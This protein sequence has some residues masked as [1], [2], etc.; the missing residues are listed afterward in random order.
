M[1]ESRN[2]KAR[3]AVLYAR[4]SS[5]EQ[6]LGY[7]IAAQQDLLRRYGAERGL[8]IEEFSD[9]ETAKTTGRP[10]FNAMLEYLN[11]HRDCRVVL[12]EKTDR[13][14]RN[15]KDHVTLAE[16]DLEIHFVKENSILTKES[17]SSD[18]FMHGLKL[19]MAKNYID[20]LSEEV[21]KGVRTKAGQGLWP[22][23][24]PLGYVNTIRVD[25]K[26]IIVP[27]P[28]LGPIV[29]QIFE[30]FASGE[31][32]LKTLAKKAYAAGFRFRK[33]GSKIPLTTLHK[34]LRKRIYTGDFKYGGTTY[35]GSHE[36][37]V[38]REVWDQV[39]EIL[40]G[41]HANKHRKVAHDF[42]Y[43]GLVRCGHC[44]CSMVGEVKKGRYVY[45]HCTGYRGKCP[46][47]YIREEML[48]EQ[49]GG[50]LRDLVVPPAVL[51]WLQS[52][53]VAS[54]QS[55]QAARA[56][57]ARR[58]QMEL[59]R[60]QGRLDVLYKDRLDGRIELST[61]D[62]KAGEIREQQEQIR[63]KIRT[64]ESMGIPP[65][66]EAVD[67]ITLASKAADPFVA[68]TAA[69]QRKLLHLVLKEASW[70]GGELRMLLREPF[71]ELRLSNSGSDRNSKDFDANGSNYD[72]WRR[73]RDSNPH[74]FFNISNLQIAGCCVGL[75]CQGCHGSLAHITPSSKA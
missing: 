75:D 47:P 45:Y 73:E 42:V 1:A 39:Q 50:V 24:A 51:A 43:S 4:V 59:E 22:S 26:R 9:V 60:L 31:Y 6:E 55:E 18:K 8:E 68:Q 61:Y 58:Q 69:E 37:L 66:S 64:I 29:T 10:G 28:V 70:K 21:K 74:G 25:G 32:S 20:N 33:S 35:Q 2:D 71:Q 52:E 17:R 38:T 30:W 15:F 11:K 12:V 54:D 49:M 62:K 44:G 65:A 72:N 7:S 48:G 16:A 27:D 46:E 23:Y 53:L 34:V 67:L 40:D 56:Q 36:P 5:K 41:R 14:Y 13:L 63:Q 3:K 19:L 57:T